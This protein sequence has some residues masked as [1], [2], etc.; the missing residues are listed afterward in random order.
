MDIKFGVKKELL[1]ADVGKVVSIIEKGNRIAGIKD[2][3]CEISS[4]S[5]GFFCTDTKTS[6]IT[7]L[8]MDINIIAP[9]SFLILDARKF[10]QVIAEMAE[11]VISI[12]IIKNTLV[13]QQEGTKFVLNIDPDIRTYPLKPQQISETI[14]HTFAGN[15]F[16]GMLNKVAYAMARDESKWVLNTILMRHSGNTIDFRATDAIRLAQ[17]SCTNGSSV[18]HDD[19]VISRDTFSVLSG[20]I[21]SKTSVKI[22][23]GKRF[24]H[25]INGK[26]NIIITLMDIEYPSFDITPRNEFKNTIKI[27]AKQLRAALKKANIVN[28]ENNNIIS[29]TFNNNSITTFARGKIGVSEDII[30]CE[31]AGNEHTVAF[32]VLYLMDAINHI[33]TENLLT[34][35]DS[36]KTSTPVLIEEDSDNGSYKNVIMAM[37]T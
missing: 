26:T 11:G 28:D 13:L 37:A 25:C 35:F 22:Y 7:D 16:L 33:E 8:E 34:S 1:L 32:D 3:L 30:E 9:F 19:V 14:M 6:V 24:L 20:V 5:L 29:L 15:E 31:Y 17:I 21:D 18:Q 27:S 12:S 10:R 23:A 2:I 4:H 36:T